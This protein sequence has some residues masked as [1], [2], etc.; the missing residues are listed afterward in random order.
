MDSIRW[1]LGVIDSFNLYA[2]TQAGQG[3]CEGHLKLSWNVI[4]ACPVK[5]KKLNIPTNL[6]KSNYFLPFFFLFP[7]EKF[8]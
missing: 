7:N 5:K 8:K 3:A 4:V 1:H 2:S 6:P